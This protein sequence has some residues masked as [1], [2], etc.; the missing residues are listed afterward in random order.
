MG[1]SNQ[2]PVSR[3]EA[4]KAFAVGVGAVASAPLLSEAAW[5]QAI[6]VRRRA[7]TTA[8]GL[9]FFSPAEHRTV[10]VISELIIPAD[11]HSPGASAAKVADFIDLFLTGVGDDEQALWH[12]G[13]TA[14][15]AQSV[16]RGG[17]PFAAAPAATQ[18]AIL[19]EISQNEADPHTV[20]EQF[21]GRIKE[22][23]LQ[24]YYTSEIG[25]H[26]ELGYKGNQFLAEFVGCTHPEHMS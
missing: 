13:L 1:A 2:S 5:A 16:S 23:T 15:D 21:F 4:L 3:R 20:L 19:S 7:T 26:K 8:R 12:E 11:D 22:R 14:I 25:I 10:D 18:V 17:K 9:K 6:A 24:G